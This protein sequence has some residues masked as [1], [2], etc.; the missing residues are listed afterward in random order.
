MRATHL[1]AQNTTLANILIEISLN[2]MKDFFG[3]LSAN[4]IRERKSHVVFLCI[5][6]RYSALYLRPDR[7]LRA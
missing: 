3:M 4:L 5:I 6:L 2:K 1:R 7:L